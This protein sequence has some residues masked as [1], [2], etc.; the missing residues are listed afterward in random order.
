MVDKSFLDEAIT[1]LSSTASLPLTDRPSAPDEAVKPRAS[2]FVSEA[3]RYSTVSSL[4]S[5]AQ[6]SQNEKSR[7]F[8]LA[9]DST[10]SLIKSPYE[11]QRTLSISSSDSKQNS[12]N[13]NLRYSTASSSKLQ[14]G[15]NVSIQ[16]DKTRVNSIIEDVDP[17][18]TTHPVIASLLANT[19]LR[20]YESPSYSSLSTLDSKPELS[21]LYA[22]LGTIPQE[23]STEISETQILLFSIYFDYVY[24]YFPIVPKELF[25]K[26]VSSESS[27]LFSAMNAMT[28]VYIPLTSHS[29][30]QKEILLNMAKQSYDLAK[31]NVMTYLP[32]PSLSILLALLLLAYHSG[33]MLFILIQSQ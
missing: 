18:L 9:T 4:V 1:E 27:F 28:T 32:F 29:N 22:S 21:N 23:I 31:V 13:S 24:S 15:R 5:P 20:S 33:C 2:S 14:R 26:M 3:S 17:R 25:M 30:E 12:S 10:V 16:S 19:K 8:S 6:A 7:T 11:H